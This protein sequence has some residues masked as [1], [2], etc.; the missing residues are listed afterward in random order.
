MENRDYE[1]ILNAMP[2]TGVYVIRETD[3]GLLYFNKRVQE[4]SPEARLGMPCYA[5]W[6]GSCSSCPLLTM[7]NRPESRAVSYNE[8]YGGVVDITAT[9]TLW[10]GQ[11]PA[12]VLTV[13]PRIDPGG[14]TYRKILRIDLLQNSCNVL[15]LDPDGWQPKP[16]PLSPQLEAFARSGAVYPDDINRF[17]AFI[18]PQQMRAAAQS[19]PDGKSLLYRRLTEG[20]FRWNLM[21]IIPDLAGE[22]RFAT[23]CVKDVHNVLREGQELANTQRDMQMAAILKSRFKIMNTVF[24]DSGQ[25]ERVD[26][27]KDAGAENALIGDY[28]LYIENALSKY[29]HPDDAE[30]FWSVLSLEHLREKAALTEDFAEESCLYRQRGETVRWIELRVIYTRQKNRMMV[31][32]LG[33]DVTREKQQEEVRRQ[34]L[35]DRAYIIGSLS[36]L[37]FATYYINLPQDTFRA[38]TQLRRVE[39]ILGEEVNCSAAMQIYASHFIHPDDR[40]DYLRVMNSENLRN[41]LRWWQPYVAVEYRKLPDIPGDPNYEWVR[42]TAVLAQTG[43]D[44]LPK[45]AVYVT[46]SIS[47]GKHQAIAAE[48][49]PSV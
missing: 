34:I 36:T 21:E 41:T 33:Q 16:G 6:A 17:I 10:E 7:G 1:K 31:N 38:V 29:V 47:G 44:D 25:C 9:R 12:F 32:I 37:F 27:T 40:A 42:A 28:A 48:N 13:V 49:P 18:Q 24:L 3:R 4:V 45:T 20:H 11:V 39:D 22:A 26:L 5:A 23:L 35:K 8:S 46:Q 43:P 15:K 19:G 30:Q 2:E 14:Y